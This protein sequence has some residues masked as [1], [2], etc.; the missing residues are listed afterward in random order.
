MRWLW[1]MFTTILNH[2]KH[3]ATPLASSPVSVQADYLIT[4]T[5]AQH[6]NEFRTSSLVQLLLI[7]QCKIYRC[8]DITYGNKS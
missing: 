8:C 3:T 4:Q 5:L 6:H 1:F 2:L 7:R